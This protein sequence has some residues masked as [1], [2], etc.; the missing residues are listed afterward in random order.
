MQQHINGN[1]DIKKTGD[2]SLLLNKNDKES[3]KALKNTSEK[4]DVTA[5][6]EKGKS[7]TE[8][9]SAPKKTSKPVA[10]K[11]ARVKTTRLIF[12]L[13]FTTKPGE[14]LYITANHPAFGNGEISAALP[15]Q[16]LNDEMWVA[17][18]DIR[19]F[20]CSR[21]RHYI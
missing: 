10:K 12:Q 20:I 14:N 6:S 17:S 16:Y 9:K 4:I 19:Y 11:S 15:L 21:K 13:K 8:K 1:G 3:R 5:S 2:E 18:I 7:V